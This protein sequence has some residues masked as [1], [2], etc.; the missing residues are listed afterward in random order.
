MTTNKSS[1]KTRGLSIAKTLENSVIPIENNSYLVRSQSGN[2]AY[3]VSKV[4][5]E[6]V[7]ECP[8]HVYRRVKC[9]HICF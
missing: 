8:D 2:G 5:G 7:C 6:W 9:K 4:D 3:N 1:R